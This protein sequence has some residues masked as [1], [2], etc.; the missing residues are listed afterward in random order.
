[1]MHWF[2][3]GLRDSSGD[4]ARAARLLIAFTT[5]TF[6][7]TLIFGALFVYLQPRPLGIFV[8]LM[9]APIGG[10]AFVVRWSGSV[11]LAGHVYLLSLWLMVSGVALVLGGVQSPAFPAYSF[12]ILGATFMI[13]RRAGITWT[14]IVVASILLIEL[15]QGRFLPRFQ[16]PNSVSVF[17]SILSFSVVLTLVCLFALLYDSAKT[18]AL[19][20]LRGANQR[21][22]QMIVQLEQASDR[23]ILS[24][25]RFLGRDAK[26]GLIGRM[27]RKTRSGHIAIEES[28]TSVSGMIEQYRQ[29]SERV[30]ELHRYSRLIVQMVSTID[31]ISDRLDMMALNVG[32]EASRSGENGKQ[33]SILAGDMRVLAERVLAETRQIQ[34]ALKNVHA[35]IDQV[36]ESSASGQVLTEESAE[37]ITAMAETFDELYTL[38]GET[39][40]AAGQITEDTLAQLDAVRRLVSA[41]AKVKA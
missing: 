30:Q 21:I 40:S 23:L 8:M 27:M 36:L 12:L 29:I 33:F 13:G 39:E 19:Q 35:Q 5:G 16:I 41:A 14:F 3:R 7:G 1:M 17:F 31:R 6:I 4:A 20:E 18:S 25:E 38:V 2:L 11:P 10:A 22:A 37:K 26:S 28:R 15:T 24:S 32:I 34:T 9:A